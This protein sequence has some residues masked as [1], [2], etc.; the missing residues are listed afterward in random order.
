MVR[1]ANKR[2]WRRKKPSVAAE[3]PHRRLALTCL[4]LANLGHQVVLLDLDELKK[5]LSALDVLI[6]FLVA[7]D[8]LV[9]ALTLELFGRNFDGTQNGRGGSALLALERRSRALA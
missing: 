5:A 1:D 4:N 9:Q 7:L 6:A 3:R 2:V 8:Q